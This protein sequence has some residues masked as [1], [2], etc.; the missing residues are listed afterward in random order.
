MGTKV[1]EEKAKAR[2]KPGSCENCGATTHK[3]NDCLERPRKVKA[4]HNHKNLA[5][6]DFLQPNLDLGF[7]GKRD[8]WN[9]YDPEM[10][11]TQYEKYR[12]IELTKE[13]IAKELAGE[14]HEDVYGENDGSFNMVPKQG[15]PHLRQSKPTAKHI[16]RNL[17][18]RE[19]TAKYLRNLDLNSA[20]YDP[21]TRSMRD[22]PTPGKET[23][24]KGDNFIRASGEAVDMMHQQMFVWEANRKGVDLHMYADPTRVYLM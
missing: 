8:R 11:A 10:H 17:R 19:D 20:Y 3:K 2:W 16:V 6:D 4:R 1:K 22:N 7:E 23:D 18:I 12:K 21:K 5:Y 14:A 24:Y 9:G 15:K 13:Q